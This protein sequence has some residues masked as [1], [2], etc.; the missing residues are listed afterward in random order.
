MSFLNTLKS[1]FAGSRVVGNYSKASSRSF[2]RSSYTGAT[3]TKP[4]TSFTQTL[5][6]LRTTSGFGQHVA[7]GAIGGAAGGFGALLSG[8][9][10]SQ[11]V[12]MG[13]LAG[14]A[15]GAYSP[16][17]MNS[18]GNTGNKIQSLRQGR[19]LTQYRAAKKS[20]DTVT[21]QQAKSNADYFAQSR[22]D[23][24]SY[25]SQG[26]A[27]ATAAGAGLAGGLLASGHRRKQVNKFN[28]NRGNYIGGM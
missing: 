7:M 5:M 6:G 22:R 20:G 13:G 12:V 28:S 15:G 2:Q 4:R 18:F 10:V 21:A 16:Q 26:R 8:G 23:I 25:S 14:V 27:V 17:I 1:A 3:A 9:S 19:A 24:T 11:G